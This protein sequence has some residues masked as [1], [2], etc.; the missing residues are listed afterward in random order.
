MKNWKILKWFWCLNDKIQH[1]LAGFIYCL[2]FTL[3]SG[4]EDYAIISFNLVGIGRETVKWSNLDIA[5]NIV[6]SLLGAF[7]G[8][9]VRGIF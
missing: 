3:I 4:R 6:G 8:K 2:V 5:C 7:V 9:V 1:L